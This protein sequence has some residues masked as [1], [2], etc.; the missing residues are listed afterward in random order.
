MAQPA[1][2]G[3]VSWDRGLLVL[4]PEW[5]VTLLPMWPQRE[6]LLRMF[7]EGMGGGQGCRGAQSPF[8]STLVAATSNC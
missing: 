6:A 5:K 2:D 4:K 3:E 8:S 7:T 1:Q